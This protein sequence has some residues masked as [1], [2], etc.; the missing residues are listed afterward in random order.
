MTTLRCT[1][2]DCAHNKQSHCCNQTIGVGGGVNASAADETMC[3]DFIANAGSLTSSNEVPNP[4]L[5]ITCNASSCVHN[6]NRSC[7]ANSVDISSNVTACTS[8]DTECSTFAE[9]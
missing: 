7:T 3:K 9:K 2:S 5:L 8:C 6:A 1:V 4:N